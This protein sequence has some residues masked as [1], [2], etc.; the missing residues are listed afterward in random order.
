MV[1]FCPKCGGKVK[2]DDKFCQNCGMA[3]IESVEV[4]KEEVRPK[5]PL[6]PVQ[7]PKPSKSKIASQI[8]GQI[9]G[10]IIGLLILYLIFYSYNCATG[11]YPDTQ[12]RA[13][14]SIYQT[15]SGGGGKRYGASCTT[16][17]GEK[18]L[19]GT[20]GSCYTCSA[21]AT[22]VTNPINNS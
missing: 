8:I 22:A 9:F 21:G 7:P 18:G 10:L 3:L 2:P 19:Y 5:I 15:F 20:D 17:D 1:N 6:A 13:C 4:P 11:K 14:Q 12:D 16:S